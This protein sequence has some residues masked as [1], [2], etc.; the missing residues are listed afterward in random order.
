M[1]VGADRRVRTRACG[2]DSESLK[3]KLSSF[4]P[5]K[6]AIFKFLGK[7]AAVAVTVVAI[8]CQWPRPLSV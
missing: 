5:Y 2:G 8:P 1:S 6:S 4:S 3:F 7:Y